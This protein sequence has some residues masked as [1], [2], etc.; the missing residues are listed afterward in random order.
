M[1][2]QG[3]STKLYQSAIQKGCKKSPNGFISREYMA[4]GMTIKQ[5]L[6]PNGELGLKIISGENVKLGIEK[7]IA[8]GC[9]IVTF[10]NHAVVGKSKQACHFAIKTDDGL[11]IYR[12]V[13]P[14]LPSGLIDRQNAIFYRINCATKT[15]QRE[16]LGYSAKY[17]NDNT[18]GIA[19][20]FKKYSKLN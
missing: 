8:K 15:Q 10:I 11:I 2:I 6:E 7:I 3:I 9:S 19:E 17:K 12:K 1:S 13:S 5:W 14:I 18:P 4:N 20:E 16:Y